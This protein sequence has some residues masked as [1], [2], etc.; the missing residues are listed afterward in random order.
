VRKAVLS[1]YWA[2]RYNEREDQFVRRSV[3][4]RLDSVR[5]SQ[6]SFDSLQSSKSLSDGFSSFTGHTFRM[7]RTTHV[8]SV[9]YIGWVIPCFRR[10]KKFVIIHLSFLRTRSVKSF[11]HSLCQETLW[12]G[13]RRVSFAASQL[14]EDALDATLVRMPVRYILRSAFPVEQILGVHEGTAD[15]NL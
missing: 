10:L 11:L 2:E 1:W 3:A 7:P 15:G 13:S 5:L 4:L 6:S 14:A 8:P 9:K 12:D